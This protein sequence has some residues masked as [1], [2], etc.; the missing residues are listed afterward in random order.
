MVPGTVAGMDMGAGQAAAAGVRA[1]VEAGVP[2]AAVGDLAWSRFELD[3]DVTVHLHQPSCAQVAYRLYDTGTPDALVRALEPHGPR[4]ATARRPASH[5][6]LHACAH[7]S[8]EDATLAALTQLGLVAERAKAAAE[9]AQHS[10]RWELHDPWQLMSAKAT[11]LVGVV[12]GLGSVWS[13]LAPVCGS[14]P[15]DEELEALLALVVRLRGRANQ[16]AGVCAT[17]WPTRAVAQTIV[18]RSPQTSDRAPAASAGSPCDTVWVPVNLPVS[19]YGQFFVWSVLVSSPV[20][21][22]S[23]QAVVVELDDLSHAAVSTCLDLAAGTTPRAGMSAQQWDVA[24]TLLRTDRAMGL[25]TALEAACAAT[26]A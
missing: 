3:G 15:G 22:R 14:S 6:R 2:L 13:P 12:G 19:G 20:V 18:T 4:T 23:A 10:R 21:A 26:A 5:L 11:Q 16:L 25:E 7:G 17:R 1:A 9:L 24:L 8:G